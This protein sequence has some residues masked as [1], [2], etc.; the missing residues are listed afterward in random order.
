MRWPRC[1]SSKLAAARSRSRV[2]ASPTATSACSCN[3]AGP[4]PCSNQDLSMGSAPGLIQPLDRR[5]A[6]AG[7][8]DAR[9]R[10]LAFPENQIAAF[11]SLR[12]A[13]VEFAAEPLL[14]HV[15]VARAAGAGGGKRNLHEPR[16]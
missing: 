13:R 7:G 4:V 15:A 8:L 1:P 5:D 2:A 9:D 14:L 11:E 6:V 12:V 10:L 3:A 16:T